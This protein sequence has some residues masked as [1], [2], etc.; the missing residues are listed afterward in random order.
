M[1]NLE[2]IRIDE[3]VPE[4]LR[5]TASNLLSFLKEYYTQQNQDSAPSIAK[6]IPK[7][8]HV[9]R[10]RLLKRLVDYYNLKGTKRSITLFFNLFFNK[11]ITIKEPWDSVLIPSDGRFSTKPFVRIVADSP[12]SVPTSIIGKTVFQKNKY[13][14]NDAQG[15][16]NKIE[17]RDYDETIYTVYFDALSVVGTFTSGQK[18]ISS[19]NFNY[20]TLYRSLSSVT[21]NNGGTGYKVGD[22]LF[23]DTR[24]N[25]SF[26]LIVSNVDINGKIVGLRIIDL[27]AGNTISSIAV[28]AQDFK[29]VGNDNTINSFL[30]LKRKDG[31]TVIP[32][33]TQAPLIDLTYN[34]S[35]LVD[36]LGKDS[37]IKG[38]LSDGIVTQDSEYYQKFSY[39]LETDLPFSK[40][41][42]SFNDLIHPAGYKVFNKIKRETTP[43]LGFGFTKSVAEIKKIGASVFQPGNGIDVLHIYA[44][45]GDPD[46][47][48]SG[49]PTIDRSDEKIPMSAVSGVARDNYTTLQAGE[50]AD[51]FRHTSQN[52]VF[53]R[54]QYPKD[55][56]FMEDFVNENATNGGF[57][58]VQKFL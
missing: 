57:K 18:L 35:T 4:Q 41:R 15:F 34:F 23:L 10:T 19:D 40:F 1:N 5:D 42:K 25:T 28:K 43:P 38:K 7:S 11:T 48:Y 47:D 54:P 31:R 30:K 20:G 9:E 22:R 12:N 52:I 58:D 16:V 14:V 6:D 55:N 46:V 32:D 37:G 26:E 53:G 2:K 24:D 8:V 3:L 49:S 17:K 13:G 51:P 39:E 33:G 36:T 45:L 56:Y 29:I 50:T 27:G 21:V 44:G